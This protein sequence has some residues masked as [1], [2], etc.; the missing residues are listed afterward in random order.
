MRSSKGQIVVSK[1]LR[2]SHGMPPSIKVIM[3]PGVDKIRIRALNRAYFERFAG[4]LGKD[5]RALTELLR[6]RRKGERHV[7]FYRPQ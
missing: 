6:S 3:I 7:S 4:V 1:A 2:Q 5:G